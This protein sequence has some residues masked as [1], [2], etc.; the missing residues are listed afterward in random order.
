MAVAGSLE[1]RV[2]LR[3]IAR[4][5]IS[6]RQA[7]GENTYGRRAISQTPKIFRLLLHLECSF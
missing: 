7:Q 1:R 4:V 6:R 3:C 2:E 5:G